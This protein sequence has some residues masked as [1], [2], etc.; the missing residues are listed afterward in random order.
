MAT[1]WERTEQGNRS[2]RL[3]IDLN[4]DLGEHD[5]LP[6]AEEQILQV[7]TSASIACG[8]HA[9][10]R[11]VMQDTAR[12]AAAAG[13][14]IG[15][16][17]SYPDRI[18]FGRRRVAMAPDV[19]A[20]SLLD[21]IRSLVGAAR[22]VGGEVRYVKP[23]GALYHDVSDDPDLAAALVRSVVGC[24]VGA[25]LVQ[26]GSAVADAARAAGLAVS[27]E[28]FADRAY[29]AGGRLAPRGASGAV[30][31]DIDQV[32]AQAVSLATAG[33]V[34]G[35]DGT[36]VP[37]TAA[38]ICVHGDTPGALGLAVAVRRALETAGVTL[39]P[40]AP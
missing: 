4:A 30:L 22:S 1:P 9:G 5:S 15:A 3:R 6:P 36:W 39:A 25:I 12:A 37:C 2:A 27:S 40:F 35:I 38:S 8:G 28:G 17:P 13:V 34:R 23:H 18:G 10:N 19:L 32:V 14:T 21:Q 7:V 26:G 11:Q 24:G 29:V 20:T 16:H 31:T 33:G